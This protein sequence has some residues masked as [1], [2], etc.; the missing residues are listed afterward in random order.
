MAGYMPKDTNF[1]PLPL[2]END[3]CFPNGIFHFNISALLEFLNGD[4]CDLS[5]SEVNVHEI[6]DYGSSIDESFLE[7]VNLA[8]PVILAEISPRMHNLIDG[9]HRVEMARRNAI[10][11]ILCYRVPPEIHSKFITSVD[12]YNAFVDYWND[13]VSAQNRHGLA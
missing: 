13:K 7:R 2:S 9:H 12:A 8:R 3:E 11:K 6:Q 4:D 5:V 1:I 10:E